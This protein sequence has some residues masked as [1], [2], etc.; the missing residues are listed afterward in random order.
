MIDAKWRQSRQSKIDARTKAFE[1]V[2]FFWLQ[3]WGIKKLKEVKNKLDNAN[4]LGAVS[5]LKIEI[6][7]AEEIDKEL[8]DLLKK[9]GLLQFNEAGKDATKAL[10][11]SWKFKPAMAAEW[12]NGLPNKVV[13][14]IQENEQKVKASIN[15]L[16]AEA[17]Q[18]IPQPSMNEVGRRIARSWF[19]PSGKPV[20]RGTAAEE[21]VTAD[22]RRRQE[23]LD[24]KDREYL[25]SFERAHTIAR[26]E[27]AKSDNYGIAEGF[28]VSGVRRVKWSPFPN[29]GRSGPRQHWR[30]ANHKSIPVEDMNSDDPMKWFKLPRGERAPWPL[31]DGL[32]A[33]EAVN[34]RCALVPE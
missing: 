12:Q 15:R 27:L 20:S 28:S 17:R 2:L 6:A 32:S 26:A 3:R 31:H 23:G 1:V 10:G 5:K 22:W 7:K 19:G 29:D 24:A 33:G 11:A 13:L 18:E 8:L 21:Q 4:G 30:M 34:C 14:L 9:F 25:F 16:V